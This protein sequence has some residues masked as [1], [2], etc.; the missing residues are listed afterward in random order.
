[1]FNFVVCEK[2]KL[3]VTFLKQNSQLNDNAHVF[4]G[5]TSNVSAYA[6]ADWF[7]NP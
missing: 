7:R 3:Y 6:E 4:N 5:S 2:A 1:M